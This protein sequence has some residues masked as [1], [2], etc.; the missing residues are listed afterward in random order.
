MLSYKFVSSKLLC[1]SSSLQ[2]IWFDFKRIE[3]SWRK[4]TVHRKDENFTPIVWWMSVWSVHLFFSEAVCFVRIR[5]V[6]QV[7]GKGRQTEH[8]VRPSSI[9]AV[10]WAKLGVRGF[11]FKYHVQF[12]FL[13]FIQVHM[14][15]HIQIYILLCFLLEYVLI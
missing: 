4:V 12:L 5:L 1:H 10:F 14:Q 7:P 15:V 3:F 6:F 2:L 13:Q 8:Q 11:W 9:V